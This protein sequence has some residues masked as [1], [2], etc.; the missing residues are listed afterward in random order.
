MGIKQLY[1][2]IEVHNLRQ[3]IMNLKRLLLQHKDCPV[4][5]ASKEGKLDH[6]ILPPPIVC[7]SIFPPN[8]D[9]GGFSLSWIIFHSKF[10]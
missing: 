2:Q 4:T 6:N 10:D 5:K 7:K 8:V 1:F 9:R 3:E